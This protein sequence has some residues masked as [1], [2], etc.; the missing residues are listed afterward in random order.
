MHLS[1]LKS[2]LLRRLANDP[3]FSASVDSM[4]VSMGLATREDGT[5]VVSTG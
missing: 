2:L 3:E 4:L 1:V 5:V